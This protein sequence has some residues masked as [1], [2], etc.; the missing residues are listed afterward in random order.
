MWYPIKTAKIVQ[1]NTLLHKNFLSSWHCGNKV[2]MEFQQ[3]AISI[4]E[5]WHCIFPVK[6]SQ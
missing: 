3:R 4:M 6:L 1:D 5:M 2:A